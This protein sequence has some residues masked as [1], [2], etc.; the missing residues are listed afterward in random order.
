[1]AT[2]TKP[3][4]K[5]LVLLSGVVAMAGLSACGPAVLGGTAL[6][7]AG[8]GVFDRDETV[9]IEKNY[10]AA[11]YLIQQA[12]AFINRRYDLIIAEPLTDNVQPLASPD[13]NRRIPEQIGV[14]LSQL[15]YRM[16]L[17][18]VAGSVETNYL[19][20]TITDGETPDFVLSG[21][22]TRRGGEMDVSLRIVDIKAQRVVAAFD[23]IIEINSRD[24]R[25]SAKP[26]PKIIRLEE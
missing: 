20:P 11:D 2:T 15:G 8:M 25:E 5:L 7:A 1:M 18:K 17:S 26:K 16:D 14:R 21:N 13:I 3:Y 10:A 9:L 24:L 4:S 22:T 12:D 6:G 19:K 23:Y